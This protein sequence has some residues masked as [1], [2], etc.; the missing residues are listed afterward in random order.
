[1]SETFKVGDTVRFRGPSP[2]LTVTDVEDATEPNGLQ[3]QRVEV[4][5]FD[6]KRQLSRAKFASCVFEHVISRSERERQ[7]TGEREVT[8]EAPGPARHG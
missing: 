7:A 4:S 8:A 3:T 2:I 5:W 1:M 6:E